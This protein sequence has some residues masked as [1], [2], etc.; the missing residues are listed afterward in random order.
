MEALKP[1]R[2]RQSGS[3]MVE[4]LVTLI[5]VSIGLLGLAQL[6]SKMQLSGSWPFGRTLY[7]STP[8]TVP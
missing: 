7:Q 1:L 6:Q 5:V 8:S 3:S 2:P 4:V